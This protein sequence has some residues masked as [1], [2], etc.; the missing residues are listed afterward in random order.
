MINGHVGLGG[1]R[2]AQPLTE[3]DIAGDL[4]RFAAECPGLGRRTVG[5]RHPVRPW[6]P[7]PTSRS[8]PASRGLIPAQMTGPAGR[9]CFCGP[10]HRRACAPARDVTGPS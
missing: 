6:T 4:D 8:T 3:V 1:E 10:G 7:R 2:V 5:H 9:G